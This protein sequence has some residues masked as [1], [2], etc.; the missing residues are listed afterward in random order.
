MGTELV[1]YEV[2][3]PKLCDNYNSKANISHGSW[4]LAGYQC[5]H[6]EAPCKAKVS[7]PC[8]AIVRGQL[9]ARRATFSIFK[10]NYYRI[11]RSL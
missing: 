5:Y 9:L 11:P 4:Y 8:C 3:G 1:Y 7:T 2:H 6:P 10:L